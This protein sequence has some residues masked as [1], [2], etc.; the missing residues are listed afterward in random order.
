MSD[1][2]LMAKDDPVKVERARVLIRK[3]AKSLDEFED[4]VRELVTMRAW[5]TLGYQDFATMWVGETGIKCPTHAKVLAAEQFQR[6]GLNTRNSKS[7]TKHGE[8]DGH[9]R[10]DVAREVGF[11]VTEPKDGGPAYSSQL[12]NVLKQLDHGVPA[13]KIAV[14]GGVDAQR[15]IEQFGTRA[16]PRSRRLGKSMDEM[17]QVSFTAKKRD[18]YAIAEWA[19]ETGVPKSEIYRQAIIE[20]LDR[21]SIN[22]HY[23]DAP[24]GAVPQ[25]KFSDPE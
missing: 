3:A 20:Y 10:V 23:G 25:P 13:N 17:V 12:S 7:I 19:R 16:R 9:L 18:D 11:T 1:S 21:H 4:Y 22:T 15:R 5:T 6:E 2:H 24:N 8:P 14:T